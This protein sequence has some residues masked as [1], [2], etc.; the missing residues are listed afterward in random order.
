MRAIMVW[1][2]WTHISIRTARNQSERNYRNWEGSFD[3]SVVF[4]N[5]KF[6]QYL[7]GR[8]FVFVTDQK[9]LVTLLGRKT[10]IPTLAAAWMQRWALL[11]SGYQYDTEYRSPNKHANADC[12]SRLLLNDHVRHENDE[13]QQISR[14]QFESL[15]VSV[16]DVRKET[17]VD[18]ILSRMLE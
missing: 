12:L 3:H 14:V 5:R 8:K 16:A 17:R 6:H 15:P 10:E 7:Y 11:L 2:Q 9:P 18:P 1:V 13:I 4:G